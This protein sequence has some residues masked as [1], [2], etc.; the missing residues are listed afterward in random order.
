MSHR[1]YTITYEESQPSTFE[2]YDNSHI[3]TPEQKS[4][5]FEYNPI[6]D[7]VRNHRIEE[8]Y[9]GIFS[10]KFATKC[11]TANKPMT[12]ARLEH[13]LRCNPDFDAYGLSPMHSPEIFGF[14]HA[15]KS[16]PGFSDIFFPICRD[17]GLSERQPEFMVNSNFFVAKTEI[18]KEYVFRIVEPAMALLDGKYRD[19]A[20]RKCRYD[21]G[22]SSIFE[23]TGIPHYTFH[24]F[25][26][27]RLVGQYISTRSLR[28]KQL[29]SNIWF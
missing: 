5:L 8:E 17:L 6:I 13:L 26:L 9:L 28:F 24:T 1:L 19:L 7:I 27:E 3:K 20:W 14:E 29:N 11:G 21:A 4:Y 10:Y 2:R 22:S 25:V 23:F 18:Y 15:E 12:K 16:H